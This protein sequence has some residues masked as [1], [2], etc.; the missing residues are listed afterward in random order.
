M[1]TLLLGA[2]V[3][4]W[5]GLT[6]F[7]QLPA[8]FSDPLRRLD[9]LGLLPA[10]SFFAPHPGVTDTVIVVRDR[11]ADGDWTPWRVAW[12]DH[13][14]PWRG[15]WRPGKRVAKLVSDCGPAVARLSLTSPE[16]VPLTVEFLLL[17]QLADQSGHDFRA[18][19]WQF[20]LV[21]L[22]N[23]WVGDLENVAW[24]RSCELLVDPNHRAVWLGHGG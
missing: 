14:T 13:A 2:V 4:L 19:R 18:L 1:A 6:L 12:T 21:D 7:A 15:L 5:L 11:I 3:C 23:W 16:A 8:R 20:G 17:A 22:R 10:W 24:F 9:T